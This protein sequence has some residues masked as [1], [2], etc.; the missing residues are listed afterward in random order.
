M[1]CVEMGLLKKRGENGLTTSPNSKEG[2]SGEQLSALYWW[3][4]K[5]E[6]LAYAEEIDIPVFQ[7][8]LTHLELKGKCVDLSSRAPHV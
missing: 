3:A 6:A 8:L 1:P 2:K 5:S 7:R 4:R